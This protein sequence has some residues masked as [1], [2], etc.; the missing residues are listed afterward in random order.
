M[1]DLFTL[2]PMKYQAFPA[3]MSAADRRRKLQ[4]MIDSGEYYYSEK[5]DG[6]LCRAVITKDHFALQTRGISKET[7]TYG[8]IQDKVFWADSIRSAFNDTTVLLGEAYIE[9]GT[10]KTVGAVLRCLPNKAKQRQI[11]ANEFVRFRI[12]DVLYYN[13]INLL[14]TPFEERKEYLNNIHIDNELINV[15]NSYNIQPNAHI[16]LLSLYFFPS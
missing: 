15:V 16:S 7:G 10:D 1:E 13:G 12:F 9:N 5:T 4:Q 2:E 3:T 6:N 8:E 11:D 14:N